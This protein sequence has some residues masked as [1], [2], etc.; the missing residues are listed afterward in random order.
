MQNNT[1]FKKESCHSAHCVASTQ[2]LLQVN[3]VYFF[4]QAAH[5]GALEMSEGLGTSCWTR[6]WISTKCEC[7]LSL[8]Q[9]VLSHNLQT[10]SEAKASIH[11]FIRP[12]DHLLFTYPG[13]GHSHKT[14]RGAAQTSVQPISILQLPLRGC[15]GKWEMKPG[16]QHVCL[17]VSTVI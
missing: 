10:L 13:Q 12:F 16:T 11:P 15:E 6:W 1:N 3:L 9:D 7:L 8:L 4:S 2:H 5:T 14:A 17:R